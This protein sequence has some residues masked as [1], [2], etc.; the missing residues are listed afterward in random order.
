MATSEVATSTPSA[1][2][3]ATAWTCAH[4]GHCNLVGRSCESCGLARRFLEDPP[5][6]VPFTPR[7]TA[8]PSFWLGL[9]WSVAALAGLFAL[10]TPSLRDSLGPLFLLFEVVG[11]GTAAVTSLF[12]AAWDRIFNQVE[13][14]VPPHAAAGSEFEA[15]LK[16]VPYSITENVTVKLSLVDRYYEE[17]GS[18]IEL[19]TKK[20]EA[21]GSLTRGRLPGRRKT[22]FSTTFL[23][24][25]PLTQHTYMRAEQNAAV[26]SFLSIFF[27]ALRFQAANLREHGGY[28]VQAYVRVGWLSRRFHKRVLTY[29]FGSRVHVG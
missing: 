12:T 28:Y 29:A 4:C 7:L 22:E 16:L 25:F 19:R 9:L 20:L 23:A 14:V 10:L 8:L 15:T 17:K 13:L 26:L 2:W 5:L 18:E 24:P 11:A 21:V 27:P 6:D 3:Q 1:A